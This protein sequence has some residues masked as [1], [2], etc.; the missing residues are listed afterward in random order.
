MAQEKNTR[1]DWNA[2][3]TRESRL[4]D[5]FQKYNYIIQ[6]SKRMLATWTT[7]FLRDW[8]WTQ[9]QRHQFPEVGA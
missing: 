9:N 6:C 7:G 2:T 5:D 4:M 1:K 3:P 8:Q